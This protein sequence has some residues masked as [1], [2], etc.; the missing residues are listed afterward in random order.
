MARILAIDPG[1]VRC[2]IAVS[3]SAETM[4]FPRPALVTSDDVTREV[5]ALCEEELIDLVVVGRPISLAGCD[6]ASTAF[7]DALCAALRDAVAVPVEQSDERL[8]TTQAQRSLAAAGLSTRQHRERIDSAAAVILLEHFM[9]V[10]R[11][12]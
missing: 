6:T 7:A 9:D 1:T 12:P 5:A 3:N 8:T 4:A 10:R 2:G 11:A